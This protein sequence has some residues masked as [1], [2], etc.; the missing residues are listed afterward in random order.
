M[1]NNNYL[2]QL[3]KTIRSRNNLRNMYQAKQMMNMG[4]YEE[5]YKLQEPITKAILETSKDTKNELEK[6]RKAIENQALAALPAQS[7]QPSQPLI[8]DPDDIEILNIINNESATSSRPTNNTLTY[9]KTINNVKA[10][11]VG[12]ADNNKQL[13]GLKNT[14]LVD[15]SSNNEYKIP[16]VGVAKLLFQSKPSEDNITKDDVDE[17][18]AFLDHYKFNIT[19]D[20][21]RKIIQKYYPQTPIRQRQSFVVPEREG[22]GVKE[23]VLIPSDPGKLREALILQLLDVEAGN[24]N[25][26]NYTNALMKEMLSQ[27]LINSKDY[28]GVLRAYFHV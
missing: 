7:Q 25:N 16:S 15:I 9:I 14:T 23:T 5:A 10:Y 1:K 27:K 28:R 18:K 12:S 17:Y 19:Q 21:K 6:V 24:N 26:F 8:E 13:F 11:S 20:S 2:S 3:N 22:E 4:L